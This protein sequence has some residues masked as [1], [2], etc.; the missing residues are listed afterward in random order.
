MIKEV[1]LNSVKQAVNNI[2]KKLKERNKSSIVEDQTV[3]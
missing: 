2:I 1:E 3:E